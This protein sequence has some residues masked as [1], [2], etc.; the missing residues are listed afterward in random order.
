MTDFETLFAQ[1]TDI[2]GWLTRDQ[3]QVLFEHVRSLPSDSLVV[4]IGSHLGRSTMV[5]A[6]AREDVTVVAVDPFLPDWKYG[7]ADTRLRFDANLATANLSGR[8]QVQQVRSGTLRPAWT[9]PVALVYVDGKHDVRTAAD[10]LRWSAFLP[11]GGRLLLHDCFSS[12]GVTLAVLLTVLPGRRLRY[13]G[14]TGSLAVLERGRPTWRN[15]ARILQELPWFVRNVCVKVVL[16]LRL[17]RLATAMGHDD[18][19]DPY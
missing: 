19:A 4:E 8:V 15:R 1:A 7:A 2:A 6:G 18:L 5:L 9:S 3:A 10:D 11:P 12:I 14:R 17:R 16:R 13:L